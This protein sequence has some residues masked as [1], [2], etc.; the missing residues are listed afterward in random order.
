M[1][2]LLAIALIGT[3]AGCS[4]G[5]DPIDPPTP[6]DTFSAELQVQHRWSHQVGSGVGQQYLKLAPLLD[7]ERLFVANRFGVVRAYHAHSGE[8]LWQ[9]ERDGEIS[10]GPGD[11]GDLLLFGGDAEVFALDKK[12]GT[13]RWRAAVDSEVLSEP[14]RAGDNVLLQAVDGTIYC[15]NAVDGSVKWRYSED[16]PALT[17]RGS[18]RPLVVGERVLVGTASGRVVAIS[19]GDGSLLWRTTVAVPR[20]RS[21]LERIVDLDAELAAGDGVLY[22]ASEQGTLAAIVIDNGQLLWTRDIA[23]HSG[24]VIDGGVLYVSDSS[25]D[26]WALSRRN[27]ATLWRQ[28]KLHLRALSAPT[29]QGG[30]LVVGDFDGYLHWLDR[31]DGRIVGRSRVSTPNEYFPIKD[32]FDVLTKHISEDRAVLAAPA[33]GGGWVY[34]MDKRGIIDAFEVTKSTGSTEQK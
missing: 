19:L 8:M 32:E 34:G 3:L 28:P 13:Q 30:Y 7:G 6:L 10:A 25:G 16:V 24:I 20:G 17:L 4:K 14:V 26:I 23:S 21:E 9:S 22:A 31:T 29:L 18:G 33:V 2:R 12:D 15:L 5:I 27:G 1:K 11:G